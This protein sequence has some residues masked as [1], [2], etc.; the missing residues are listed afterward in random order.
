MDV[1]TRFSFALFKTFQS[2]DGGGK[3]SPEKSGVLTA[4]HVPNPPLPRLCNDGS[5]VRNFLKIRFALCGAVSESNH[6]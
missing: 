3:T 2:I 6:A 5:L 1:S 4:G